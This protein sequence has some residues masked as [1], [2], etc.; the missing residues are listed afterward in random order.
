MVGHCGGATVIT[1]LV[2]PGTLRAGGEV[3]LDPAE[4]HHLRVRR[5]VPGEA[6]RVLD[7]KGKVA[8]GQIVGDP[9]EGMIRIAQL[10]EVR[11]PAVLGLAVGAGDRDRF[12]WLGEKAAELGVTD[13]IPL[14]TERTAGV[15]SRVRGD[16]I[17][18]L[19]RRAL[20]SIKQSGTA[21]VPTV[22]PPHTLAELVGRYRTGERWL[23]D[24]EGESPPTVAAGEAL[25]VAVGPEGGF[26]DAERRLLLDQGWTPVR[27]GANTLRFETAALAAAVVAGLVRGDFTDHR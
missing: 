23:A 2:S 15:G 18:K 6:L 8:T 13:L 14:E 10:I 22:H 1:L 11:Q 25:W 21:W 27:L 7:G 3:R 4:A 24:A 20:E 5:S 19:Q 17:E 26:T 12:L 9:R 16:H